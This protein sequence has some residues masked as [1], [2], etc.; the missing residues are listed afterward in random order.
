[1]TW[2][3]ARVAAVEEL[4][5]S[6]R[7]ITLHVPGFTGAL[8]GQHVD[9]RLTAEDGYQAVRSYSLADSGRDDVVELAVDRVDDGEV[10]PYL[11]DV[12]DVGDQMEV[13][14]PLGGFFVWRPQDDNPVQLVAGGSGIV[15]LAAMVRARRRSM[16]TTEF[17]LLYSTRSPADAFFA[18]ELDP[19]D[20]AE[21]GVVTTH[22]VYT[23]QAPAGHGRPPGRLGAHDLDVMIPPAHDPAVFV[24]GPTGF[25]EAT[26]IL[27]LDAGYDPARIRTERFGGA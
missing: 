14:G 11:V 13:R 24:C 20:T 19:Q 3:E 16:A 26:A 21:A 6:A 9:L 7:A 25:V 4:T 18:D 5:T 12:L 8:A 23:R 10:S 27:L 2:R 22:W 1:M 17:R 15:P